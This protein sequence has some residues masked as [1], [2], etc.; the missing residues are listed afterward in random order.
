MFTLAPAW[1]TAIEL[2]GKNSAVL[3]A[4]MNTA[5]QIG[6][7]LSPLVLAYLVDHFNNWSLPLHV[8]SCLYLIAALSWITIHPEPS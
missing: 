2:G 6:G 1:A 4:A 8:L 3:S 7:M 5:G